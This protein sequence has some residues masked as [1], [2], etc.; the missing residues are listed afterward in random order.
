MA[1]RKAAIL[2]LALAVSAGICTPAW[3]ANEPFV[4]L[5]PAREASGKALTERTPDGREVPVAKRLADKS[6]AARL[7]AT[8]ASGAAALLP[9][10]DGKARIL[11]RQPIACPQLGNAIIVFLSDED[12]GFARKDLF[13]ADGAGPPA[14]CS[15]YFVDIT[16][17]AG[18]IDDGEFEEVLAHEYGHVLLRR[19]LGPIPPTMSRNAHSILTVT[20][21]TTAFDE[22]FGEHFQPIAVALTHNPGFLQRVREAGNSPADFWLSRRETR[23]RE[24]GI[25]HGDFR[26]D[27]RPGAPGP[28]DI[29]RWRAAQTDWSSDPC[30]LRSGE[31]M[32]ASEGVAATLFYRLVGPDLRPEPLLVRYD[33]LITILA[34]MG[35]WGSRAPIV[36]LVSRWIA[37]YPEDRA[38]VMSAFLDATAGATFSPALRKQAQTLSCTGANGRMAPFVAALK[39]YRATIKGFSGDS[40]DT[41]PVLGSNLA[42]EIWLAD[43]QLHTPAAPWSDDLTEPL[44]LD[45]NTT[46]E[47]SLAYLLKGD[48]DLAHRIIAARDNVGFASVNDAALRAGIDEQERTLLTSMSQAAEDLPP[49]IRQ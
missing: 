7:E 31:Q 28:D 17:D 3:A 40:K 39:E 2:H 15:D 20:D 19:L 9:A 41:A 30:R 25:P 22:G 10:L 29:E 38:R 16:A 48:S 1:K 46:D 21:P 5:E 26:F 6:M 23:L 4:F 27:H 37:R 35:H 33:R 42:P 44:V 24:I 34:D 45:L 47:A 13:L 43:P 12:G 8:V 32:M 11:S 14:L 49:F 36:D 18:T